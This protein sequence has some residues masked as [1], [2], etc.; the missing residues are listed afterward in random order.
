VAVDDAGVAGDDP[1]QRLDIAERRAPDVDDRGAS[2]E[3]GGQRSAAQHLLD[4]VGEAARLGED[5]RVIARRRW[6]EER[7]YH[8]SPVRP[9]AER[10]GAGSALC[11]LATVGLLNKRLAAAR[12]MRLAPF[13]AS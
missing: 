6:E 2:E 11:A 10:R 9:R 1:G 13:C 5:L 3:G 7:Q 8:G 4:V 12:R